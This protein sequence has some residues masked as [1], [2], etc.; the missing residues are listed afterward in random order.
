L[1]LTFFITDVILAISSALIFLRWSWLSLGIIVP[2]AAI[3]LFRAGYSDALTVFL[4]PLAI[5]AVAG[6]CLKNGKGLDRF[7]LVSVF[8]FTFLFTAEYHFIKDFRNYDMIKAARDNIVLVL[9]KPESELNAVFKQ[10]YKSENDRK[11]L[12][13][14]FSRMLLILKDDK[15]LQFL[16]DMMPFISSL[17]GLLT[18]SMGFYLLRKF[19]AKKITNRSRS[20]EYFRLNDYVIFALIAGWAGV[21]FLDKEIYPVLSIFSINTAL[22]T[23]ML[24]IVQALGVVK[25]KILKRGWPMYILPLSIFAAFFLGPYAVIFITIILTG[26]GTLDLWADFRRLITEKE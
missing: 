24:Y 21:I 8:S 4:T 18:A 7:I 6:W 15:W 19:F 25:F 17:Y 3:P 1:N 10:Y 13:E 23:S 9:D 12:R 22:I 20:L 26:I 2:I 5:G 16:R 14:E 11:K